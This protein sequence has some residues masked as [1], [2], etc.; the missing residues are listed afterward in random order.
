MLPGKTMN[1]ISETGNRL[2][3]RKIIFRERVAIIK[4]TYVLVLAVFRIL[5]IDAGFS[6]VPEE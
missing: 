4:Q 2:Q 3:A 1:D 5:D 6:V